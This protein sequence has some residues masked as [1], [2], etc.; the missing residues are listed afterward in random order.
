[1]FAAYNS[2]KR[3]DGFGKIVREYSQSLA[4]RYT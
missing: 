2:S 1:M 3:V 4:S